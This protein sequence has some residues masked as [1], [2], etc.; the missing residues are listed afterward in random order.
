MRAFAWLTSTLVLSLSCTESTVCTADLRIG[1][2]PDT[3]VATGSQFQA[4]ATILGCGGTKVLSDVLTWLSSDVS[5]AAVGLQSGTVL[6]VRPGVAAITASG[7]TYGFI[8]ALH[9]TV[10]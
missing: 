7:K 9:V 5:I 10:R 6:G 2:A 1:V 3:T 4:R 8:G